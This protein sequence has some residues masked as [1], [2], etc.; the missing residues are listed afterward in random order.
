MRYFFY[1]DRNVVF[2]VLYDIGTSQ[3]WGLY[4]N[5]G[6]SYATWSPDDKWII[7]NAIEISEEKFNMLVSLYKKR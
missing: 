2:S 4:L 6:Y 1:K 3:A 5:T 7:D